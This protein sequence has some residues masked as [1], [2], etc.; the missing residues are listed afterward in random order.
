MG[1]MRNNALFT[2]SKIA[3][4]FKMHFFGFGLGEFKCGR[5]FVSQNEFSKQKSLVRLTSQNEFSKQKSV[6]KGHIMIF[7]FSFLFYMNSHH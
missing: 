4:T 5:R 6:V 7:T 3:V 1:W 2:G